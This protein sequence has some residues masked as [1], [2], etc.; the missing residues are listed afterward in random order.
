VL[1]FVADALRPVV[2]SLR[3][4]AAN[5]PVESPAPAASDELASSAAEMEE[6]PASVVPIF[7]GK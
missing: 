4:S 7:V 6:A 2:S 3:T 5:D 1:T